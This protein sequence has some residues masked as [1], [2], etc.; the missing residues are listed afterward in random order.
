[1]TRLPL[2]ILAACT[3]AACGESD[4]DKAESR[5]APAA[6]EMVATDAAAPADALVAGDGSFRGFATSGK[7][8]AVQQPLSGESYVYDHNL[9]VSMASDFIRARFER[10]RDKCQNDPALKCKIMSASF[11]LIGEPDAPLPVANLSVAMPHDSV[12]PFEQA[13]MEPLPNESKDDVLIKARVTGAQNVTNQVKDIESRLAQLTNYRDRM[14]ELSKRGGAKTDDLIKIEGEIS[15]T[16]AEIEGIEGQ[17]RDLAERIA[18]EN[19][20]IAFEA[21]STA[22]DALQPVRDV[23][24]NSLRVLG[25][26]AA[27]VLALMVGILPWIPVFLL[28]FFGFRWLWRRVVR[29]S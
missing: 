15:R 21:Q 24:Q 5:Y 7:G 16:Q 17:R 19:L 12:A 11:R 29:A 27:A 4:S 3:L 23:W 8:G 22:S 28:G 26:S 6:P 1:M 2:V 14:M 20:S 13:L 10:A 18:K 25:G 9:T